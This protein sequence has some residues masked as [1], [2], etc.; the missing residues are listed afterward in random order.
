MGGMDVSRSRR[1]EALGR[2]IAEGFRA[3]LEDSRPLTADQLD[4]LMEHAGRVAQRTFGD[5][6]EDEA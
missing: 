1:L 3:G 2:A 4:R 5:L 6:D